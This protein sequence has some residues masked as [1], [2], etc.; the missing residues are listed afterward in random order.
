MDKPKSI[1]HGKEKTEEICSLEVLV[2]Q[3]HIYGTL[4]IHQS[5]GKS[6]E[7]GWGVDPGWEGKTHEYQS[8]YLWT[9]IDSATIFDSYHSE[10]SDLLHKGAELRVPD[11]DDL[12]LPSESVEGIT[13]V[14]DLVKHTW[15][16]RKKWRLMKEKYRFTPRFD[17]P[18]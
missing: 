14:T 18:D 9:P 2:F 10:I 15:D 4:G 7:G 5:I 13:S 3:G 6:F 16:H 11:E 8:S 17:W 1:E 12:N